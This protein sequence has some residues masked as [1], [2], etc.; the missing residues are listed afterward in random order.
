[1]RTIA[2]R[3]HISAMLPTQPDGRETLGGVLLAR[4]NLGARFA[5]HVA[6]QLGQV[7]PGCKNRHRLLVWRANAESE[8]R[9]GDILEIAPTGDRM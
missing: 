9:A 4:P 3:R 5:R 7:T 6:R 1:M 8:A 2:D